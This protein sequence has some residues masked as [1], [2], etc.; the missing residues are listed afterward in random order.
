MR[1]SMSNFIIR[2]LKAHV[3]A[4]LTNTKYLSQLK[5]IMYNFK[6]NFLPQ[7]Q[8]ESLSLKFLLTCHRIQNNIIITMP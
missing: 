5:I 6:F 4:F 8:L 7:S 1:K 2:M 3:I